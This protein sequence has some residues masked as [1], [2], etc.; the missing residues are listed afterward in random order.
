MK[1]RRQ[2]PVKGGRISTS[3]CVLPEIR[4]RIEEI[5]HENRVSRSWVEAVLLAD[6]LGIH[7]Q[8]HY[9]EAPRNRRKR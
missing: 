6:A 9:D 8:A 3:T 1:I 5:A 2:P 7:K 4:Y